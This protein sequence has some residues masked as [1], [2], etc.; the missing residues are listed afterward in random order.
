MTFIWPF[1]LLTLIIIPVLVVIYFRL[2]QKRKRNL[3]RYGSL[4]LLQGAAGDKPGKRRY[5]PPTIFLVGLTLLLV[6]MARPQTVVSMPRVEGTVILAFD[7]SG[8]MAATDFT[9]TRMDAAKAAA[10]DFV[11]KQPAGISI[12]I[13]AFS[14]NGFSVQPPTQEKD[15]ILAAI[16]RLS[17][18]KGTSLAHGIQAALNAI[19]TGNGQAPLLY[20]N[21]QPTPAPTPTPVP[22]GTYTNAAIVMLTDGEN[23]ESPDPMAAAQ[24]A[25]DR[26]VRIYT[27]GIG[28]PQGTNLHIDGFTV[29]TQLDEALLQQISQLTGGTYFNAE[30]SKDLLN[31]Y[32]HLQPMLVIKPEKT[33]VTSLFT[34]VS[35]LVLLIGGAFSLLWFSRLP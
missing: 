22:A 11:D 19:S 5:V 28:S 14:D 34:G 20:S 13:V 15:A 9:P 23:N 16:D 33:E 35:L 26:G 18:Q 17:P 3:A 8:S 21:L 31:I 32:D 2:Q 4:G 6:A 24:S 27:I 30:N 7:I 10:R 29:H 25:V 1:M 12:G